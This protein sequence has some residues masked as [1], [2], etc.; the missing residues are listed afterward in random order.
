M[1]IAEVINIPLRFPKGAR[2]SARLQ[3]HQSDAILINGFIVH[4]DAPFVQR[5]Y[6]T[7]EDYGVVIATSGATNIDPGGTANTDGAWVE[8]TAST[9][10][11]HEAILLCLGSRANSALT[12]AGWLF[13]I[14]VG[15]AGSEVVLVQDIYV[16]GTATVDN[17]APGQA[18]AKTHVAKGT[19]LS[20]RCKC[21]TTDATDR[22]LG[23]MLVG[24]G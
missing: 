17:I 15:A 24:F 6:A 13:D 3:S 19:R 23:A 16:Y 9:T 10:R 14:G 2:V 12:S 20:V 22:I 7:A 4:Y 18:M 11:D 5:G 21:T 8:L 1:N